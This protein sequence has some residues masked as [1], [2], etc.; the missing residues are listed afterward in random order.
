MADSAGNLAT[1]FA[2][3][4]DDEIAATAILARC[5]RALERS[6]GATVENA[7]AA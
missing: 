4:H 5:S 6:D 2:V 3:R 1:P 7:I